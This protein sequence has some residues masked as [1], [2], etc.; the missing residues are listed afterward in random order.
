MAFGS[1]ISATD[2]VCILSAFKEFQVD[3]SFF[4]I[5]YGESILNDVVSIVF[6]ETVVFYQYT[7]TVYSNF[8]NTVLYFLAA[9]FGSTFIGYA[10]GYLTALGLRLMSKRVSNIEQIEIGLMVLLP[11]VSYLAAQMLGLS[12]IVSILFNGIA[13]ATY[14]KPNLTDWSKIVKYVFIF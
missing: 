5:V 13:H 14:T 3:P 12:G 6:Y 10:I 1:L 8:F 7:E 11:W 2:P 9:I 4:Q